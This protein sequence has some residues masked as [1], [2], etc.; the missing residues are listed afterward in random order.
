MNATKLTEQLVTKA[1]LL[2]LFKAWGTDA[3]VPA[4]RM[5]SLV[6]WPFGEYAEVHYT[7]NK[8]DYGQRL[9]RIEFYRTNQGEASCQEQ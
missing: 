2:T 3:E 9:Y 6:V 8:S 1:Q 5:K 7:A 4:A